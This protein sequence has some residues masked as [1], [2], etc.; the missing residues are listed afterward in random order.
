MQ[1]SDIRDEVKDVVRDGLNDILSG[2]YN[3]W[4][5]N[6]TQSFKAVKINNLSKQ[7][8]SVIGEVGVMMMTHKL[9]KLMQKRLIIT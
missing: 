5:C 6:I 3:T 9:M 2:T 1:L 7:V 4:Y 8:N